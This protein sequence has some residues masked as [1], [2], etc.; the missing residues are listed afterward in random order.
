MVNIVIA[1]KNQ[2]K[3]E[4]AKKAFENYFNDFTITGI[5][6]ESNVSEQPVNEETYMGAKNRIENLKKYCKGNNIKADLY[7]SIESGLDNRLLGKWIITSIA[8]IEDDFGFKSYGTS[9]S[10]PV[11]DRLVEEIISK[12]LSHVFNELFEKDEERHNKGGAIQ[13]LTQG[14]VSRLD[15]TEQ[16]F[17]MALTRYINRG[18]WE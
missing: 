12:D 6:V 17:L 3:I 5:P 14:K 8:L 16:A 1:T 9:S 10:Y 18:V 11:P 7:I 4:G 2:C 15:L 13:V